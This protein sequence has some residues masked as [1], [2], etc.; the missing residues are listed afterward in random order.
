ME[1]KSKQLVW[2]ILFLVAYL[3][4]T[5]FILIQYFELLS[6]TD[7]PSHG[8]S[9]AVFLVVIVLIIGG[10][11]YAISLVFGAIGL[12]LSISKHSG[13]G[14]IIFFSIATAL[15]IVTEGVFILLSYLA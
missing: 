12:F 7:D 3:A 13:K 6:I 1:K 9:V 15:P 14:N 10:I 4:I 2:K 5:A 8:L 11:G